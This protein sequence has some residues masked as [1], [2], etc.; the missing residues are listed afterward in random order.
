MRIGDDNRATA[1]IRRTMAAGR[2]ILLAL[3]G[4]GPAAAQNT[5]NTIHDEVSRQP[6][7]SLC[8]TRD[9]R[10]QA[11]CDPT[12]TVIRTE[13]QQTI[14]LDLP[15]P[16][17]KYC[18]A[19]IGVEYTQRDTLVSVASTVYNDDCAA[20]SGEFEVSVTVR[21]ASPDAKKLVFTETWRRADDKPV[22]FTRDYPI[23]NDTDVT[24]VRGHSLQCR[25]LDPA[26]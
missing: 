3:L 24:S 9:T 12:E 17:S 14:S 19:A 25:C 8:T 5:L 10:A 21:D 18:A 2:T 22:T 4:F 15:A 16:N 11:H 1:A 7:Y 13:K 26:Q 20:S 6:I 23:G